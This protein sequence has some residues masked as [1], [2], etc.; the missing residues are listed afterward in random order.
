MWRGVC[1]MTILAACALGPR[2]LAQDADA[3]A[4]KK[5]GP[6]DSGVVVTVKD[7][8]VDYLRFRKPK[9][10]GT[11]EEVASNAPVL[12][13]TI[14]IANK[15]D[16]EVTY[17]TANGIPGSKDPVAGIR[18]ST[19]HVSAVVQF[20]ATLERVEGVKQATIKPGET[21]TDV[22]AFLQLPEGVKPVTLLLPAKCHG[23]SGTWKISLQGK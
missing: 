17:K 11:V 8:K 23:N 6:G 15:G 22:L 2:L 19:G 3:P 4:P 13:I 16:K 18:D 7:M 10:D 5:E 21:V 12:I 14:E 20:E 1:A 9:P